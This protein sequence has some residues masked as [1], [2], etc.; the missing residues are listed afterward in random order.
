VKADPATQRRLLDLAAVDGELSRIV[1]RRASLPEAA[2]A[3]A[4]EQTRR[5]G[6]EAVGAGETSA[7]D[8]DR[9]IRRLE[10]DVDAVRDRGRRDR[11]LLAG[12]GVSAKQA[13]DLQHELETLARRQGVLEDELLEVLEQRETVG[14]EL[15]KARAGLA[16]AE[17]ALVEASDRRDAAM[18]DLN[19]AEQ[20]KTNER[21]VITAELPAELVTLYER[22]RSQGHAGA[23]LLRRGACGGC[24]L[25]LD[26]TALGE[27]RSAAPDEIVR[28]EE[29][30]SIL[31]RTEESGL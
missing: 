25:D 26:R 1:H 2:A 31:V 6:Q 23:A 18:A 24:R 11:D 28:C 29:C 19:A 30:G 27:L 4:A 8:L 21:K 3:A 15:D 17:E 9:D 13:V 5:A 12:A 10:R 16:A 22:I 20:D 14:A 7:G